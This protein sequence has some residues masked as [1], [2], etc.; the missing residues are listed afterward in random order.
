[1]S[2]ARFHAADDRT[3]RDD[4]LSRESKD[5]RAGAPVGD[6]RSVHVGDGVGQHRRVVVL[7]VRVVDACSQ[8]G[9]RVRV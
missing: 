1:M 6:Q 8:G 7:V 9:F 3:L 5:T 4:S 2:L